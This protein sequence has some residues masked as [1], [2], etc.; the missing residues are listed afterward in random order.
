MCATNMSLVTYDR[1][2]WVGFLEHLV[3]GGHTALPVA[4][5]SRVRSTGDRVTAQAVRNPAGYS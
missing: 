4:A 5:W 1:S 3:W 2:G